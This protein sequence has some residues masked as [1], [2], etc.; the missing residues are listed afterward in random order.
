MKLLKG[1]S[2]KKV[3]IN[4]LRYIILLKREVVTPHAVHPEGF[5]VVKLSRRIAPHDVLLL[6]AR[7]SWILY[8]S[9][10]NKPMR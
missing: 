8:I 5:H 6:G 10:Q 4:F 9:L 7:I 3:V 2:H 1:K